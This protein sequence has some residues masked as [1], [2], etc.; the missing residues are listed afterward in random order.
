MG[1]RNQGYAFINFGSAATAAALQGAWH[2]QPRF[3]TRPS[4]TAA[5]CQG[6]EANARSWASSRIQRIK[7]PR[8]QPF[9]S[10][11]P[12]LEILRKPTG[13]QSQFSGAFAERASG[14]GL[15]K[16][17]KP[18]M[19][20]VESTREPCSIDGRRTRRGRRTTNGAISRDLGR[21]TRTL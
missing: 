9:M 11:N 3:G 4:V 10:K 8:N 15:W 16:G 17:G 5:E 18:Q 20:R 13:C 7:N 21:T 14:G 12:D 6:F 19:T 2:R 1:G